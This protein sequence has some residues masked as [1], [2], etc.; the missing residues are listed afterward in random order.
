MPDPKTF[1]VTIS[2]RL[3]VLKMPTDAQMTMVV[4]G[5]AE[6]QRGGPLAQRGV[7]R[8]LETVEALI[9][10]HDDVDFLE[11]GMMQGVIDLPDFAKI[12]DAIPQE[13]DERPAPVKATRARAGRR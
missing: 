5:S 3:I 6:I 11:Q 1:E 9:I 12:L 7:L 10:D 8:I 2:S 13:G 4:R